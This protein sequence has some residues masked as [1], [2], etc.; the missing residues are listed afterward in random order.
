[1]NRIF[2]LFLVAFLGCFCLGW[3]HA[4]AAADNATQAG[5]PIAG[6]PQNA[7]V[8][9]VSEATYDFGEV[10]EGGELVHDFIIKNTGKAELRIEQVRPG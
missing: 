10:P 9:Q 1:M 7:P 2:K 5:A 6:T 4:A 8:M 3:I